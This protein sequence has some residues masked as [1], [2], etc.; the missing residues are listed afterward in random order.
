MEKL[1]DCSHGGG[2]GGRTGAVS[3]QGQAGASSGEGRTESIEVNIKY[4]KN[5]TPIEDNYLLGFVRFF[6]SLPNTIYHERYI[7]K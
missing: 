7:D 3:G 2:G 6:F 4:V 1:S 5:F